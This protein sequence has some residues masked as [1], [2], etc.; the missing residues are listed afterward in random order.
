MNYHYFYIRRKKLDEL[1]TEL[2]IIKKKKD[3]IRVLKTKYSLHRTENLKKGQKLD[4]RK[5]VV[6]CLRVP[7]MYFRNSFHELNYK[8]SHVTRKEKN[9]QKYRYVV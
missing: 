1:N 7:S 8:Y 9:E 3:A 4:R 5:S 6:A 2:S